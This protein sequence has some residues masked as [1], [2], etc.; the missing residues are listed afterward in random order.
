[1][2]GQTEPG[3]DGKKANKTAKKLYRREGRGIQSQRGGRF[4]MKG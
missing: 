3:S 1:M 4:D 2:L